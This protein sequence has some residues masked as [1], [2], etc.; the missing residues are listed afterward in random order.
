MTT[1]IARSATTAVTKRKTP[2]AEWAFIFAIP[3]VALFLLFIGYSVV[4]GFWLGRGPAN[5]LQLFANET[6]RTAIV[7]TLIYLALGVNVKMVLALLL[8][9]F[10]AIPRWWAKGLLVVFILPWAIPAVPAFLS[11]HWMLS[12][13]GMMN[14]ILH[15]IGISHTPEWL[16][17][18]PWAMA[19]ALGAYI[20]KWLPF[21]TIILLAAR[22]A[23]PKD[24]YEAAEVD[25]ATSVKRFFH[26][27]FPL[28]RNV[29][30]T[31]TLLSTIWTLSDY[32]TI[33]FVT[34]G[35][36]FDA[37]Q[38]FAT[39]GIQYAFDMGDIGQGIAIALTALPVIVPLVAILVVRLKREG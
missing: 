11:I 14:A 21:W 25:G 33:H 24:V 9:G 10:F 12:G 6:Y 29:Y 5:Y 35:G 1:A 20:W 18:R 17:T 22:M 8:S 3:Y 38:V 36:P 7:N 28:L 32:N 19:S 34:G 31:S 15:D 2:M 37:T 26:V 27:T 30:L 23:L 13:N 39:L 4:Y 16:L